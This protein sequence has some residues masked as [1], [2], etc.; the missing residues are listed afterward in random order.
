[1]TGFYC[2]NHEYTFGY[3]LYRLSKFYTKD[4]WDV[5]CN[6]YEKASRNINNLVQFMRLTIKEAVSRGIKVQ[7]D[8]GRLAYLFSRILENKANTSEFLEDVMTG[9]YI[10]KNKDCKMSNEE[11]QS[12]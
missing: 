11:N 2:V 5:K 6:K 3:L 9:F 4:D 10:S 1:M 7:L 8:Y 12:E